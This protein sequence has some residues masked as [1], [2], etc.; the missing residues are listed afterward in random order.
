MHFCPE[1]GR[2]WGH[3]EDCSNNPHKNEP[4]PCDVFER[5]RLE[6]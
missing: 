2:E 3:A 1:C 5:G 6:Y 4:D